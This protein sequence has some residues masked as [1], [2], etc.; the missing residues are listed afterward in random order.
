MIGSEVIERKKRKSKIRSNYKEGNEEEIKKEKN[1]GYAG[2]W[3]R[4]EWKKTN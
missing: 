3:R 4:R 1:S 2:E